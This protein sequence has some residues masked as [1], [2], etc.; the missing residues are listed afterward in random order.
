M[1]KINIG[2]IGAGRMGSFHGE[3]IAHRIPEAN[4]YA[5]SDP[6]R[7]AADS[8]LEK[9]NV[10]AKVYTDIDDLFQDPNVDA[11][12]NVSPARTHA[13][14]IIKAIENN[15]AIFCEKPMG[16]TL[17]EF[18]AIQK[19]AEGKNIPVQ[20]GFNRRFEKGFKQAHQEIAAG[21]LGTPQLLRS[22]TR[23]P[24]LSNAEKIPEWTIFIET[25]IHDFDALMYL[26][27]GAKPVE[28]Y[29]KADALIRPDLKEKGFLDTAAVTVTFDN[30]CIAVVDANFQAV[31]GYDVRAEVFGSEGMITLGDLN[32]TSMK[33]YNQDGSNIQT[34]KYDQD[35]LFDAYVE[36]LRSFTRSVQTG[37]QPE[38]SIADAKWALTLALASVE[39]V[40]TGGPVKI[41]NLLK[42]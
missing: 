19:A 24:Q 37:H 26:N 25:L 38:V 6:F 40:K 35:L 9:L 20:V 18:E 30:G 29:A 14:N 13:S 28:V 12:V 34:V 1:S 7:E 10:E 5:V 15:K 4:L 8:L 31:Y 17:E 21:H 16:V 23:D 32:A 27:P 39:S 36:E 41:E 3:T 2:L 42:G 11:V 22:N 33:K